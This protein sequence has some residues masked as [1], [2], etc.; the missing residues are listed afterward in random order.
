M[1]TA[2]SEIDLLRKGREKERL[3]VVTSTF[4][5]WCFFD[6]LARVSKYVK[7]SLGTLVDNVNHD[8]QLTW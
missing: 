7:S 1:H 5:S 2:H 4:F 8:K 3:L 6:C